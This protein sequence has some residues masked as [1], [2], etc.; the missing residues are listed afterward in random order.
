MVSSDLATSGLKSPAWIDWYDYQNKDRKLFYHYEKI[1]GH[2]FFH[3][4]YH[5]KSHVMPHPVITAILDSILN[6]L[7]HWKTT[8]TCQSNSP[9]TTTVENYQQIVITL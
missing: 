2:Y 1:R 7:Q 8:T 4:M 9:N 6:I 5:N 3:A